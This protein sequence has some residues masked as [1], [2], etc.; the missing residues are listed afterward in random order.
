MLNRRR[1][2]NTFIQN[3]RNRKGQIAIFIALAFQIL[4]LFFAMV[5][6]VGLLVHHKINLQNSVDLAAYYGAMRQAE[7]MNAI[8]HINY[9]IRQSWK[10][11]AWRYRMLGSAGEW[12]PNCQPF[13]KDTRSITGSTDD[14]VAAT[15]TCSDYQEAPSF[16]ITYIPFKPMPPDE[17]T[18]KKMSSMSGTKLWKAPP[19]IAGFQGFSHTIHNTSEALRLSALARCRYFGSYNYFM[20]GKFV[21]AFNMD[22]SDRMGA[23]ASISRAM[24]SKKDDFYDIDGQSVRSGIEQTLNNNLTS[25]NRSSVKLDVFNSLGSDSCNAQNVGSDQPAK[26]LAPVRIFPGFGYMDTYCRDEEAQ[27]GVEPIAKEL[28]NSGDS[29]PTHVNDGGLKDQ[30]M[31]LS[32]FVGYI[33]DPNS[34]YNFSMGVEKNPWCMAYVGVSATATPKIPFSPFGSITLKARAFYKPFGGRIGP[35]Y[36]KNWLPGGAHNKSEG[37]PNEKIDPLLP[38]RI[39]DGSQLATISESTGQKALR[40]ANYSRFVGDQYGLKT[41]RM[42]GHYAE[43]IYKLD[44]GWRSNS[45]SIPSGSIYQGDDAPNFDHWN[46]LP[47]DF[48]DKS[49]GSGDIL[50]FDTVKQQPSLMRLL[51]VSAILPDTFDNTY[52]SIDPDFYHNYYLRLRDGFFKQGPGLDYASKNLFRPDIGYR[53]NFTKGSYDFEKFSVKD[54]F[55]FVNNS[56]GD[57]VNL[58]S[59]MKDQ[60]T[61]TL[62]DWKHLLTGWVPIGLM[63]YSLDTSKF[64][65]CDALPLGAEKNDPKPPTTGNCV[66]GGSTGFSVKMVSSDYLRS[67]NLQLGGDNSGT[68]PLNNPPPAEGD[69]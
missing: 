37:G 14:V 49:N 69:F 43:A 60:F 51:E 57:V 52:Y 50:A 66:V 64:G 20:L 47:F 18:C 65:K 30:I 11:L 27:S 62:S 8:A 31:E 35:W 41:F 44:S 1:T 9:Q 23:I 55:E 34:N 58:K 67:S 46:E 54:Q 7:N 26:W 3:F 6:N 15:G 28:S 2:Q 24:S 48:R 16:C 5:I 29:F 63:D 39:T 22:Q 42:L 19:I 59:L 25:A 4:F 45:I 38:P 21:V 40:A 10:L 68:G 36:Y 33:N 17:N 61:F 13:N 56:D 53:K 32:K 12:D